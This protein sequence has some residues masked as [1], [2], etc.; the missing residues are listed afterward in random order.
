MTDSDLRVAIVDRTEDRESERVDFAKMQWKF[1][2]DSLLSEQ[3]RTELTVVLKRLTEE[4]GLAGARLRFILGGGQCVT[5]LFLGST[6]EVRNEL[7]QLRQRS[8]LYL[9]LGTGEKVTV[10]CLRPLDARHSYGVAAVANSKTL[11][12][13]YYA[14]ETA[15]LKVDSIEPALV[16]ISRALM[17]IEGA[18]DEPC[19]V[20]HL[21]EHTVEIG[22][23]DRGRLLLEYRPGIC[24]KPAEL[25]QVVK[26]HLS[27]LQ[28]HVARMLSETRP[29]I[30]TVYLVGDPK[31]VQTTLREFDCIAGLGVAIASPQDI[32]A[33]WKLA[34][35]DV[36]E[37]SAAI[38]VLGGVLG[39][40]VPTGESEDPN[41]MDHITA[42]TREPIKPVVIRSL[43]PLAAVL[44]VALGMWGINLREE[45]RVRSVRR[46]V[47]ELAETLTRARELTLQGR[48]ATAKLIQLEHLASQ[49]HP[50]RSGELIR[51]I[52]QCM[53][54]DVWLRNLHVNSSGA[55]D[56]HGAS[57]LEA[58][59][60][61][62][63]KWLELAP[64]IQDVA[65]RSTKS[66]Q[67]SSGPTVEFDL[68]LRFED[69]EAPAPE[70]ARN[71]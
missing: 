23:C 66:G 57:F 37:N 36:L 46:Q 15:G 8:Q 42:I 5:K 44:L 41:F 20:V 18:P 69:Q 21:E 54:N 58:G 22:V 12:A 19:L 71:E 59:V 2:A 43:I 48:A 70:V 26:T 53:P 64:G 31:H 13:L 56:L 17:R 25:V 39:T 61:D 55:V 68:E 49:V 11:D 10:S 63:A 35:S 1:E 34:T 30:E 16:A 14:S 28:R 52:A 9:L 60:F 7:T 24:E 4:H 62:F 29:K 67:S 65:L 45:S 3:G 50:P 27:R 40:Y 33:T 38:A 51:R 6:E 47:D 32:Q